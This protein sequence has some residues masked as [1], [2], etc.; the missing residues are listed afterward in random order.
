MPQRILK[1]PAFEKHSA[2]FHSPQMDLWLKSHLA[3]GSLVSLR[4]A[5]TIHRA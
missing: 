3:S 1:S 4:A 2:T 5:I